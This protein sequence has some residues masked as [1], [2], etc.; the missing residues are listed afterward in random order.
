MPVR[1]LRGDLLGGGASGDG[2]GVDLRRP[3]PIWACCPVMHSLHPGFCCHIQ[4]ISAIIMELW[5]PVI[6]ALHSNISTLVRAPGGTRG[7]EQR[8]PVE[9]LH[10]AVMLATPMPRHPL[11]LPC[12]GLVQG[13]VVH[14][15]DP[16]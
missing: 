16:A 13:G 11:D 3:P 14:H 12:R 8:S 6:Q 5:P 1:S 15:Q 4:H 2:S 9:A 10:H 7:P